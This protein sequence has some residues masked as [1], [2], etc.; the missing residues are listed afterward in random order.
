MQLVD[1]VSWMQK[2]TKKYAMALKYMNQFADSCEYVKCEIPAY[3]G[4][5]FASDI[6]HAGVANPGNC[7]TMRGFC[8][9]QGSTLNEFKLVE[10]GTSKLHIPK[11]TT[12]EDRQNIC[13]MV[14]SIRLEVNILFF[15]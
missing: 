14:R 12:R 7:S 2:G 5:V 13:L 8:Q 4:V 9:F 1:S 11:T 3:G 10:T 15:S 6:L